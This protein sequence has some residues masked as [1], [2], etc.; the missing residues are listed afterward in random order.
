M[1]HGHFCFHSSRLTT[2]FFF[3]F[4]LCL[5]PITNHLQK[6]LSSMLPH[7]NV[8]NI[9]LKVVFMFFEE[10]TECHTKCTWG[11]LGG[12]RGELYRQLRN[13]TPHVQCCAL[14][15]ASISIRSVTEPIALCVTDSVTEQIALW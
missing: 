10:L 7:T 15:S 6:Q 1:C 8:S 4:P 5:G 13:C 11:C 12:I 3:F 2:S 9:F 14:V